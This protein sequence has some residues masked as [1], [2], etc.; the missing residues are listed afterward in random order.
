MFK[1]DDLTKSFVVISLLKLIFSISTVYCIK[2]NY[3]NFSLPI[4]L[5]TSGQF[6]FLF[7]AVSILI[8]LGKYSGNK[9]F[10]F[11]EIAISSFLLCFSVISTNFSIDYNSIQVAQQFTFIQLPLMLIILT[12]FNNQSFSYKIKLLSV[13]IYNL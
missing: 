12:Y 6:L 1:S 4:I 5:L 11:K 10:S 2:Y 3:M 13:C 9:Q 7:F 8:K